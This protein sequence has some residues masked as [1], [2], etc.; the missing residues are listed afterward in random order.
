MHFGSIL[1]LILDLNFGIDF[2]RYFGPHFGSM[3]LPKPYKMRVPQEI[4]RRLIFGG[5]EYVIL[6]PFWD[7]FW[8]MFRQIGNRKNMH[9]FIRTE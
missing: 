2:V 9:S 7:T 4:R 8:M 5:L 6:E 1:D 3:L